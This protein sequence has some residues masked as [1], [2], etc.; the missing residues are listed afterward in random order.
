[1]NFCR[2]VKLEAN[3]EEPAGV[4]EPCLNIYKNDFIV[5]NVGM[6]KSSSMLP[7][8]GSGAPLLPIAPLHYV[9]NFSADSV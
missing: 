1:M 4:K 5:A 7:Y 8:L 6:T 3:A 2:V 9:C